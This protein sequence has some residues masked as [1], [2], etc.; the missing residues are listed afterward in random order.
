VDTSGVFR[1]Y[2]LRRLRSWHRTDTYPGV[3][4][5]VFWSTFSYGRHMSWH[6][7]V[8][9]HKPDKADGKGRDDEQRIGVAIHAG[10][11]SK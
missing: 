8:S 4:C 1:I 9:C 3:G 2:R 11:G 6:P 10:I 5:F 7:G